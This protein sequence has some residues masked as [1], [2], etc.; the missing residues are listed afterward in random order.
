VAQAGTSALF[1]LR[2]APLGSISRHGMKL[3]AGAL[4]VTS[5]TC[6]TLLK[7]LRSIFDQ[8]H[9]NF[10]KR[11]CGGVGVVVVFFN[12]FLVN[13]KQSCKIA[14]NVCRT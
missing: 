4:K 2:P 8:I 9:K 3:C 14:K 13:R 6:L 12:L 11:F 10:D 7:P 1:C 5:N